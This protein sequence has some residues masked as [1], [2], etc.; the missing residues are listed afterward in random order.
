MASRILLLENDR[1]FARRV[2]ALLDA[3]GYE[4][5]TAHESDTG[6]ALFE[7][8]PADLVIVEHRLDDDAGLGAVAR[9]RQLRDGTNVPVVLISMGVED[10]SV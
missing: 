5:E 4:T 1:E 9:L 3:W 7:R 8:S 2:S 10:E 6:L